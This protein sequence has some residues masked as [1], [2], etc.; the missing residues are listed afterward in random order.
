M[1]ERRI[2]TVTQIN[3]FI[4]V[5]LER[6]EV[7][8]NVWIRGEISNF[9]LHSSGHIYMTLKDEGAVLRAVM[10]KSAASRLLFKPEN[11][12]KVLARGRVGVFERDGQYQLYVEEMEAEGVGDLYRLFEELK[13]KLGGEG[14]F[15]ERH[16]KALV[17]FPK[18]I[19]IVTSPTGAAVRDIINILRRR[20]PIAEAV[21]YPALVQGQ[22]A[23]ES[24]VRGIEYFN[25]RGDTDVIIVGRG[26]GSIEDLWAF[27]EEATVRAVFNS[28]I[29]VVSA[30]GH[31]TDFTL[32][33]FAADLRAPTPSAAAEIAVPDMREVIS[34]V[35]GCA[36]RAKQALLNKAET[37]SRQLKLL[38]E[39][40]S[41]TNFERRIGDL[42]LLTDRAADD[43]LR[44]YKNAL[45]KKAA[46]L[47]ESAA[48][49]DA[50]S[51]LKVFERGYS[52]AEIGGRALVSVR[53]AKKGDRIDVRLKDGRVRA[54]VYETEGCEIYDV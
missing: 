2:A 45:E 32:T 23:S 29:P 54:E 34:F 30:V 37:R 15:D 12:M 33:D 10:F 35:E 50:M 1:A 39:R 4:K 26:G 17:P 42:M 14:L 9:K 43:M 19:G 16:K 53:E 18:K 47:S 51:P 40:A 49:L 31:E 25:L 3:N 48:R 13:K 52:V 20:Y 28:R 21:L 24:V 46:S 38:S 36:E 8:G 44:A 41:L 5:L 22:G 7:L 11:G 6:T 27:N